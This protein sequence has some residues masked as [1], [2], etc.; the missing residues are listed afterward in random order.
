[1]MLFQH[2]QSYFDIH[3]NATLHSGCSQAMTEHSSVTKASLLLA[4]VEFLQLLLCID[5]AILRT[6]VRD[7]I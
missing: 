3:A 7:S 5:L 1:M 6:A 4:Q 2:L